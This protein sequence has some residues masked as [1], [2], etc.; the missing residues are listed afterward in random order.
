MNKV[1]VVEDDQ[2]IRQII[3]H[4]LVRESF[5]VF[6][7]EDGVEG[8]TVAQDN[9]PDLVILDVEMPKMDGI[10]FCLR[11]REFSTIPVIFLSGRK[12]EQDRIQG[13]AAGG[14]D[15]VTKPFSKRELVMKVQAMLRRSQR[16]ASINAGEKETPDSLSHNKIRM[17]LRQH[18]V[19]WKDQEVSLTK[20]EFHI[21]KVMLGDPTRVHPRDKLMDR[22]VEDRT[23]DSHVRG[24]RDK[25]KAFGVD[26]IETRR[27]VGFMLKQWD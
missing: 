26:P 24:I 5:T 1:L 16:S 18:R 19:F 12:D 14:D 20:N 22:V 25:F 9:N 2:G 3:K 17:D 11:L 13:F 4:N 6:E 23:I 7:A 21:L 27:G 8:L 15:Y 10:D